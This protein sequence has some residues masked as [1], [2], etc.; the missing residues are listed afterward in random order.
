MRL[1]IS[2]HGCLRI[3]VILKMKKV[4]KKYVLRMVFFIGNNI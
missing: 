3:E 1:M 4:F 2:H